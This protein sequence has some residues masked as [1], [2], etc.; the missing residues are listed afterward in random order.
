MSVTSLHNYLSRNRITKEALLLKMYTLF[1]WLKVLI[2]TFVWLNHE[3]VCLN[4]LWLFTLLCHVWW[5]INN[6]SFCCRLS[7]TLTVLI[8]I[9]FGRT[10]IWCCCCCCWL[11]SHVRGIWENVRQLIP[12]QNVFFV[13]FVLFLVEISLRTLIPL[14]RSGSVHSG[15]VSWDNCDQVL[16]DKLHVSSFP[17]RFPHYAWIQHSRPTPTLLGQGCMRV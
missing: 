7:A 16:S 11:F 1:G 10:T 6:S 3:T 5:L 9:H 8:L 15:S 2:L 13:G 17:D 4:L 14:F 12:R